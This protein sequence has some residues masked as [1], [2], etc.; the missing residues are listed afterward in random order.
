ML[1]YAFNSRA[2]RISRR[3][4][5]SEAATALRPF[6]FTVHPDL[7]GQHPKERVKNNAFTLIHCYFHY[8]FYSIKI[9]IMVNKFWQGLTCKYLLLY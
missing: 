8:H 4:T 5:V 7:F 9:V 1:I 2:L 3:L 6:Y